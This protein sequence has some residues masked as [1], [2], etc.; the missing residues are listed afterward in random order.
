[1]PCFAPLTG[2]YKDPQKNDGKSGL[3][4]SPR[5]GFFDRPLTVPCGQCIG[6][7]LERSRQWAI[8]CV[9]ESKSHNENCFVTLTYDDDNL[10]YHEN[11]NR[12]DIQKFFKRLRRKIGKFRTFYCGEY[13]D[14]TKR[15]HFH[16]L[17]FGYSPADAKL[18]GKSSNGE[19]LY[20]SELLTK[21]WGF[22]HVN[23]GAVN[24]ESA[25]YVARYSTKKITGKLAETH[26]QRTDPDTGEVYQLTPEFI[27]MSLKPGIGS[28]WSDKYQTDYYEKDQIIIR[29]K[30]MKPPRAYDKRLELSDPTLWA[31]T[32]SNRAQER[33]K[34]YSDPDPRENTYNL[35]K[36][37][38]VIAEQK[39]QKRNM[40]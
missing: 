40:E 16:T 26:Y 25:A 22:G 20:E 27:G 37:R 39:L 17:I 24:F 9:H 11:L 30:P 8:R 38:S 18:A 1:M 34:K 33:L 28:S 14:Q 36:A 5:L 13:G 29:G 15:P 6:C 3:T 23:F 2:Y 4:F 35:Y 31:Q 21:T 19:N 32:R 12:P 7:R 10:P